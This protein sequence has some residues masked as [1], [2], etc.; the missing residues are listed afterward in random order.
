MRRCGQVTSRIARRD[1]LKF[2]QCRKLSEERGAGAVERGLNKLGKMW[3][4]TALQPFNFA[5]HAE[6]RTAWD[7]DHISSGNEASI[8]ATH[9]KLLHDKYVLEWIAVFRKL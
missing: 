1:G 7:L 8:T 2:V 9:Q 4:R 5:Q 6:D 3:Y